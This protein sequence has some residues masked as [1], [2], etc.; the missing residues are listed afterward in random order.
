MPPSSLD[1]CTPDIVEVPASSQDS[2]SSWEFVP[3]TTAATSPDVKAAA[4]TCDGPDSTQTDKKKRSQRKRE[5]RSSPSP[6][7]TSDAFDDSMGVDDAMQV[8]SESHAA[9]ALQAGDDV[10][11]EDRF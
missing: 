7:D 5:Q 3:A 4:S 2:S 8:D 10:V 11:D 1:N 6:M 9:P